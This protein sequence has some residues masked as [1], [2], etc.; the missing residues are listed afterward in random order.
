MPEMNAN[1][2]ETAVKKPNG[3]APVPPQRL[4]NI[5]ILPEHIAINAKFQ[6]L[7]GDTVTPES[8]A[9]LAMTMREEGQKQNALVRPNGNK[10]TAEA[11]PW[12]LIFGHRRRIAAIANGTTLRC[13]VEE[14]TDDEA[15]RAALIEEWQKKQF[16]VLARARHVAML[17]KEYGWEGPR[18]TKLIAHFLGVDETTVTQM[19]RL[20][21]ID[22]EIL[23]KV[24]RGEMTARAALEL[25]PV[26]ADARPAVSARAQEL[27]DQ[28]KSEVEKRRAEISSRRAAINGPWVEALND[29]RPSR[30][31]G[32]HVRQ[33]AR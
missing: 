11:Q 25:A 10:K 23:A 13:D 2:T 27:A 26:K 12:E 1:E 18:G 8:V 15:L 17:R 19:D 30:V 22:P 4:E 24:D 20:V 31:E 32:K 6:A 7:R 33:A 29:G 21:T 14:L 3:K 28:A 5:D 9:S 16:S